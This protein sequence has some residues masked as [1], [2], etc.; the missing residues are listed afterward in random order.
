MTRALGVD[1]GSRRI[2][3]ALSDPS[4]TIASP[5]RVLYRA[6]DPGSDHR[7]LADLVA[8]TGAEVVV[9]G[10]PLSLSGEEGPAARKAAA[11]ARALAE[12]LDVPVKVHDERLTTVSAHRSLQAAGMREERR[13]HS[14]DMV[15]AAVMLQSW[16]D[17]GPR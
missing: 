5:Y 15:A 10:V 8:E 12:V 11:E 2:G 9:V 13:R 7:R 3:L 4:G 16:L 14:V 17:G 1:L 6:R